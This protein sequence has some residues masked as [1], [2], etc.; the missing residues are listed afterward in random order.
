MSGYAR[1]DDAA[2][3]RHRSLDFIDLR[4]HATAVGLIQLC[5]ELLNAR[6]LSAEGLDRIKSAICSE[7]IVA[8]RARVSNQREFDDALRRRI[9]AVFPVAPGE[10]RRE[11]IGSLED[12]EGALEGPHGA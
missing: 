8:R 4:A 12:F 2:R 5:E 7:L 11:N 3:E 6:V 10:L 9:D 1:N